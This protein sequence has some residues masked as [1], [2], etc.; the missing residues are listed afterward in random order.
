MGPRFTAFALVL[1][2]ASPA[3][4]QDVAPPPGGCH[5]EIAL[6]DPEA[7]MLDVAMACAGD[8]PFALSTYRYLTD[9]HVK[10]LRALGGSALEKAEAAWSLK[11]AGGVARAAYRF[12]VDEMARSTNSP[13]LGQRV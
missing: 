13:T 9:A 6:A 2:L 4:A 5:Y 3:H 12:D 7:R 8:G 11:G 1:A 10:E